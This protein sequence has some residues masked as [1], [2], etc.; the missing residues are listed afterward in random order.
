MCVVDAEMQVV[1]AL[2]TQRQPVAEA[3]GQG[4]RVGAQR[5]HDVAGM[6]FGAVGQRQPPA[7]LGLLQRHGIGVDELAA[8]RAEEPRVAFHQ[9]HGR[10]HGPGILPVDAAGD[11]AFR[12]QAGQAGA[13]GVVGQHLD[14]QAPAVGVVLRL[15]RQ[16]G[17]GFLAAYQLD[18][19]AVADDVV[20]VGGT[21]EWLV[22]GHAQLDERAHVLGGLRQSGGGGLPP[23]APQPASVPGQRPPLQAQRAVAVAGMA[24]QFGRLAREGVGHQAGALDEPGVAEAGAVAGLLSVHQTD[25]LALRLQGQCSADA[26]DA[27]TQ[28]D[29]IDVV[30]GCGGDHDGGG[31]SSG[32]GMPPGLVQSSPTFILPPRQQ[33]GTEAGR[34][35]P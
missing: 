3:F 24:Q 35:Y 6:Q 19:A 14:V 21:D 20:Q 26:D 27:G 28:D 16:F 25:P 1:A 11:A 12:T 15:A 30:V 7:L 17:K 32:Q 4:A 2:G 34:G 18:P 31:V 10:L 23:V 5:Q 29:D 9:P 8:A 22:L 13:Q 33:G